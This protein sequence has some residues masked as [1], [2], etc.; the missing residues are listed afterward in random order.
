MGSEFDK[1][2]LIT[3]VLGLAGLVLY[4]LS[5]MVLFILIISLK[6]LNY[7]ENSDV[8]YMAIFGLVA[9]IIT[10][11]STVYVILA[12]I[13]VFISGYSFQD[14]GR[15]LHLFVW[16]IF[17]TIASVVNIPCGIY[18]GKQFLFLWGSAFG[19][20]A[21]FVSLFIPSALAISLITAFVVICIKCYTIYS[22]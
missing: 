10:T 19:R 6:L 4:F 12:L 5:Q 3:F 22:H 18:A 1:S 20:W 8:R 9:Q 15:A 21:L 11:L 2:G 17:L 14:I 7:D 16:L 13:F